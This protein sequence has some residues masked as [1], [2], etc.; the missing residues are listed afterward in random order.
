MRIKKEKSL[1]ISS[2]TNNIPQ[3]TNKIKEVYYEEI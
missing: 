3:T 2:H 1:W